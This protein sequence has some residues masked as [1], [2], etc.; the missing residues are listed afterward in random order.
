MFL[1]T[2]SHIVD[3]AML[4]D[5]NTLLSTGE[6]TGM[7]DVLPHLAM[8][9]TVPCDATLMYISSL[10]SQQMMH[11][12]KGWQA[13]CQSHVW[14]HA[15]LFTAEEQGILLDQVRPWLSSLM[16]LGQGRKSAWEAF[17]S[18]ARH[19]IHVVFATSPVGEAFR[20]RCVHVRCELL[21]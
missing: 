14:G 12:L 4:G 19:H 1:L 20:V 11:S 21:S 2:D 17:V 16:N 8:V 13:D 6:I 15:G 18:R 10:S 3:D 7:F 5:V 9:S